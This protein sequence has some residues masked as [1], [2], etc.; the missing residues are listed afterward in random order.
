MFT[1]TR[2]ASKLACSAIAL[3]LAATS[4]VPA[5]TAAPLGAVQVAYDRPEAFTDFGDNGYVTTDERRDALLAQLK[6]HIEER[7]A[8]R[9]PPGSTLTVTISDIDM[10]GGFEWWHGP[11]ADHVRIV[12]DI[13]PPRIKLAFSLMDASGKPLA[14]GRRELTDLTFL[15]SVEYRGDLLR[16]EKKLLDDWLA[17]EFAEQQP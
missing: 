17:K 4:A 3:A 8:P 11:R 5:N 9:I 6:R 14:G 16:Y 15:T 2:V 13:Y 1:W 12:K 7:A 10:A